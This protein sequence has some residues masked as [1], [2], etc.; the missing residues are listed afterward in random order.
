MDVSENALAV[1][2][3]Q[4]ID[5]VRRQAGF[6]A[7]DF[8]QEAALRI[9][10][11]GL[12]AKGNGKTLVP[13]FRAIVKNMVRDRGRRSKTR[14]KFFESLRGSADSPLAPRW[15]VSSAA[16]RSQSSSHQMSDVEVDVM[17]RDDSVWAQRKNQMALAKMTPRE[18]LVIKGL[19]QDQTY[20]EIAAAQ[21]VSRNAIAKMAYR[22]SRKYQA[23][24]A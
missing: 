5:W 17:E 7:E 12:L 9:C 11:L 21:G 23:G 19:L 20:D 24:Q 15:C 4:D 10:R 16:T 22:V 14:S 13:L 2:L 18:Q 3:L 6:D 1:E 8:A